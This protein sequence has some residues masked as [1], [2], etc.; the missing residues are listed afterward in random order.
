MSILIASN[1]HRHAPHFDAS[2]HKLHQAGFTRIIIQKTGGANLDRYT[3]PCSEIFGGQPIPYDTAMQRLKQRLQREDCDV[4]A[5]M[6][7]DCFLGGTQHFQEYLAEFEAGGYDFACHA[8][9]DHYKRQYFTDDVKGCIAPVPEI[10]FQPSTDIYGFSPDPHF[11]NAYLLMRKSVFDK[12]SVEDFRNSRQM[13]R[14][15]YE[16]GAKMGMHRANY[17]GTHSHWGEEWFHVGALF[18]LYHHIEAG[19]TGAV[20]ADSE[21]DKAR[22][23]YFVAAGENFGLEAGAG[24]GA[25]FV[26]S[27]KGFW[28]KCGGETECLAAWKQLAKGT[29]MEE[30]K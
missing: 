28:D 13:I 8:V 10:K 23:G 21:F 7:N 29:C 15:F 30:W 6:D 9:S 26:D 4:I 5:L 24:F 17:V 27:L 20:R 12:L 1:Y 19:N 3:G 16:A 2:M 25:R 11:E 18:G 22:L 14:A